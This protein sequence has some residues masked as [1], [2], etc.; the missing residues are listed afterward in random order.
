MQ[1][2][3]NYA[4]LVNKANKYLER[5]LQKKWIEIKTF[6]SRLKKI[7]YKVVEIVKHKTNAQLH[8]T[9]L[10]WLNWVSL[11]G[12]AFSIVWCEFNVK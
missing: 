4:V 2:W 9:T 11:L 12:Y 5:L 1:W 8:K 10:A 6:Q 3:K 7:K